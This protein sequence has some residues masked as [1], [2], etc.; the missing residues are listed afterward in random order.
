MQS[1]LISALGSDRRFSSRRGGADSYSPSSLMRLRFNGFFG[2]IRTARGGARGE[3]VHV[4][5]IVH[6]GCIR[7]PESFFQQRGIIAT[8]C[9]DAARA[10][11]SH[12][13]KSFVLAELMSNE[14]TPER[15]VGLIEAL[16][17]QR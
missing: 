7:H 6:D 10:L 11:Q 3:V 2:W 1:S 17:D 4:D 8:Y 12:A 14:P 15:A 16:P 5:A 13:L 9:D